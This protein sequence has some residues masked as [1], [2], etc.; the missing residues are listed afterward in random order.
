MA[1][2]SQPMIWCGYPQGCTSS[3]PQQEYRVDW[4]AVVGIC[5]DG[6][7]PFFELVLFLMSASGL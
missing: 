1:P 6:A 2:S 3:L 5:L 4:I 7:Q